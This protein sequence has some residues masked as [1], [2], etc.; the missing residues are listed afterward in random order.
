MENKVN[1]RGSWLY[2]KRVR[3]VILFL[4]IIELVKIVCLWVHPTFFFLFQTCCDVIAIAMYAK[5]T[6]ISRVICCC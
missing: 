4:D 6:N 1:L 3:G 5:F 2:G